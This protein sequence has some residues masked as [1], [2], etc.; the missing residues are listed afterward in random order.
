MHQRN[1]MF[2]IRVFVAFRES[3]HQLEVKFGSSYWAVMIQRAHLRNE[4]NYDNV[5]G[6][7]LSLLSKYKYIQATINFF[8]TVCFIILN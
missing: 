5:G 1:R 3:I 2:S 7:L 4:S 8:Q 6:I